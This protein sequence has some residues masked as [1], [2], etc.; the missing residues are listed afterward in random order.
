MSHESGDDVTV[1]VSGKVEKHKVSGYGEERAQM[2]G[3]IKTKKEEL[4]E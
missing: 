3:G 1:H 4:N 2:K